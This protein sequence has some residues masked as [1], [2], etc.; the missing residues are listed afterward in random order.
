MCYS[1][2][3]SASTIITMNFVTGMTHSYAPSDEGCWINPDRC[4][5]NFELLIDAPSTY[6]HTLVEDKYTVFIDRFSD[7]RELPDRCY[8]IHYHKPCDNQ[9]FLAWTDQVVK[10][11]RHALIP[12]FLSFDL[13]DLAAI[14]QDEPSKRFSLQS[15][16][17]DEISDLGRIH[18]ILSQANSSLFVI[19]CAPAL[20]MNVYAEIGSSITA[21][22]KEHCAVRLTVYEYPHLS[23]LNIAMLYGT[24][25][26]T[27]PEN[28]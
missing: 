7:Q 25:N 21:V 6:Q 11:L 28:L 8:Q 9:T 27:K 17:F 19:T 26:A 3:L 18:P 1:V 2:G 20:Q 5:A 13:N 10:T 23:Q 24:P 15:I 4:I 22:I 12:S 16:A 14:L